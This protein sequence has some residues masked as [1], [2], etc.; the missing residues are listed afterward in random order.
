MPGKTP[1]ERDAAFRILF[2]SMAGCVMAARGQASAS[3]RR[4]LLTTSRTFFTRAFCRDL[5]TDASQEPR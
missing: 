2:S 4:A 5:T 3:K 1:A